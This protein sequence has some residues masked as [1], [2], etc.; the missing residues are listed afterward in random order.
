MPHFTYD[1]F[2]ENVDDAHVY[3][4]KD[5]IVIKGNTFPIASLKIDLT[6][7]VKYLIKEKLKI[8]ISASDISTVHR[9]GKIILG[10]EA[11][12]SIIIEP[13]RI[14][15]NRHILTARHQPKPENFHA[16]ENLTPNKNRC[17]SV[18]KHVSCLLFADDT[19][20]YKSS[21]NLNQL[22]NEFNDELCK[23]KQW[24]N[25]ICLSFMIFNYVDMDH[26]LRICI[27]DNVILISLKT[28]LFYNI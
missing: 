20:V 28:Y 7:L 12:R 25:T 4:R 9:L 2:E 3:E 24:C 27:E 6:T 17:S 23:I 21:N 19:T 14:D 1:K 11:R 8:N 5:V 18:S 16:N 22:T 15:F 10:R 13:C 26:S